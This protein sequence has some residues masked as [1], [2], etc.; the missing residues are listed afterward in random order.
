MESESFRPER[1]G[2]ESSEARDRHPYA[3]IPF[4]SGPRMHM[5]NRF[6]LEEARIALIVMFR[7]FEFTLDETRMPTAHK[8]FEIETG[9]VLK[10]KKRVWVN[11]RARK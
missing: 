7:N 5:G 2:P 8:D 3:Y 11:V 10:S 9:I 6:A 4:G 1:F